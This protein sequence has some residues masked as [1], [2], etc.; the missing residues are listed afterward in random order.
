MHKAI[1]FHCESNLNSMLT[2]T[3]GSDRDVAKVCGGGRETRFR[4]GVEDGGRCKAVNPGSWLIKYEIPGVP[5]DTALVVGD[6]DDL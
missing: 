4:V 2:I 5:C 3:P 6:H 1:R